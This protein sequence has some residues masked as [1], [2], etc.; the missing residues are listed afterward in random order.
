MCAARAAILAS[1]MILGGVIAAS[2]QGQQQPT[3]NEWSVELG[4]EAE[5]TPAERINELNRQIMALKARGE[6]G[7]QLGDLYNDLGVGHAQQGQWAQARDAFIHALQAKPWDP[8]IHRNLGLVFLRLEDYDLAIAELNI[9]LEQGGS[10]ALDAHR[11]LGQ[12]HLRIGDVQAARQAYARGLQALGRTPGPEVCRL[13]LELARLERE[14]GEAADVLMTLETWYQVAS[15]WQ[16]KAAAE[17]RVDGVQEAE[18]IQNNLLALY[19]QD[20]Q[21]LEEAGLTAEALV[22][23][24]KAHALAPDRD[25]LLPRIVGAHLAAGDVMQAR[26]VVR[27]ARQNHPER[28]GTWLAAARLHEA[29][30][31]LPQA[32]E[33]Y[34]RIDELTPEAPGLRLKIGNLHMRLGQTAEARKYLAKAIEATDTPPEI[35]YNY[36]VS[37]MKDQMFAAAIAPLQRVTRESPQFAGGWLALAQAYRAREQYDRAVPAYQAALALQ[38]DAR[39]AYNLGVTA[40]QAKQWDVALA[41]YDSTLAREPG[42]REAAYNRAVALMQSGRLDDADIAFAAYRRQ[43]P[44]NYRAHLNHGVTLYRLGR[45]ADAVTVYNL[46]LEIQE[47]AEVWDNMGL[48]YQGLGDQKKAEQC[49]KEAEKLRGK[50]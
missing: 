43:D 13:V 11:L 33:A 2:G 37:L 17:D 23:Y 32:L 38:P 47:T 9:Y 15:A 40:G 28:V 48:A 7:A 44:A 24:E 39:T 46:T 22:Y 36:A 3:S 25:D 31:E 10:Q 6:H 14:H 5:K 26:V 20:A 45:H 30:D 29:Q 21:L 34:K 49:F 41:A 19:I 42:H 27:L 1:L 35:I 50:S 18:A 16:E 12:A 4:L 8:D